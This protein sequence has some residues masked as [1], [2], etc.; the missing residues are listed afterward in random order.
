MINVKD[1]FIQYMAEPKQWCSASWGYEDNFI[2]YHLKAPEFT[3]HTKP[4]DSDLYHEVAITQ[5][6]TQ[7]EIAKRTGLS[8]VELHYHQTCVYRHPNV[9]YD[10]GKKS[11]A[12]PTWEPRNCGRLYYFLDGGLGHAVNMYLNDNRRNQTIRVDI[13]IVE[14]DENLFKNVKEQWPSFEFAIPVITSGEL[15]EVLGGQ[16]QRSNNALMDPHKNGDPRQ[17]QTFVRNQ[18]EF[19]QQCR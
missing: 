2:Y 9:S 10:G 8:W 14:Q 5:E 13:G 7:G 12:L 3:I 11:M 17:Y 18:L 16:Q 19:E 6:W 15:D 4:H 1:Q